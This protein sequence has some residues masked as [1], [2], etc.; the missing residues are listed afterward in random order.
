MSD[1]VTHTIE[2]VFDANSRVLVL[3]SIP[4]PKSRE[5]G[6]FYGHPRNRFWRV[7]AAVF[8]EPVPATIEDKRDLLLRRHIALWDVAAACD[9]EGASDASIR[10]VVPNDL[11][12]IFSVADIAAVFA[13]GA[14][15]GAL[16][17]RLCE[18][19]FGKPCVVLPS[20]SPANAK[21]SVGSLTRTYADALLAH[22]RPLE[23]PTLDTKR[24]A[25]LEH[26]IED[27]GTSLGT[28]MRRAGSAIAHA[29]RQEADKTECAA[30]KARFA[31]LCGNGNNG[32]DGWEAAR[33]L[34][35]EGFP[36]DVVC[37]ADAAAL[38]AHP[39]REAAV[40]ARNA[41]THA[42]CA[43]ITVCPD[44]ATLHSI[45]ERADVA[46]DALFGT[47]FN[48]DEPRAPFDG[49]IEAVND[50]RSRGLRVVAADV[51]SGLNADTGK[52]ARPCI[53]ADATVT[54]IAPKPGLATP[55]AFAFCGSVRVAPI[56]YV[57]PFLASKA[58]TRKASGGEKC[59]G[60]CDA[61]YAAPS[62]RTQAAQPADDEFVRAEAED[63]DGYD[64][65][66]DRIPDPTPLFEQ[67][68]WN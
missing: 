2:P 14:K 39:A 13:T 50:A 21:E 61:P 46:I 34:A 16:Y 23:A 25:R 26:A 44:A 64:P 29:A 32:G 68:P 65:Y 20:T 30:G 8:D 4:S 36:I 9:I 41:L 58:A 62:A 17:A 12:R 1:H 53:K 24:I 40:A 51:P 18:K 28:L 11:D 43:R 63:D 52:A 45:L 27:G 19:R 3:G 56:A 49:W 42:K 37:A 10:N 48:H 22:L 6:F 66:S 7:L 54:M 67:D 47:G 31:I 57:E 60:A 35:Q 59:G 33:L 55:Y 15:A 38:T 5:A